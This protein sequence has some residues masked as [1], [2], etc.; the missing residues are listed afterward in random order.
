MAWIKKNLVFVIC[1]AVALILLIVASV[2]LFGNMSRDGE[3]QEELN[4]VTSD[5]QRLNT[6][7]S[8]PSQENIEAAKREQEKVRNFRKGV[9]TVIPVVT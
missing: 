1:S 5:W 6:S 2:F 3:V 8:F 9:A 7:G 4:Q